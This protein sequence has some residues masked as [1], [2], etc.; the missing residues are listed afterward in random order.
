MQLGPSLDQCIRPAPGSQFPKNA[1]ELFALQNMRIQPDLGLSLDSSV[2]TIGSCFARNI[3]EAMSSVG[4]DVPMLGFRVPRSEWDGAR[5]N[6]I[7]NRYTPYSISQLVAWVVAAIED[8]D[9]FDELTNRFWVQSEPDL[10]V[11]MDLGGLVAVSH[12]RF[13]ARRRELLDVFRPMTSAELI[14]ITLGQTESWTYEPNGMHWSGAPAVASLRSLWPL[15]R[16]V[17]ADEQAAYDEIAESIALVRRIN[18]HAHILLTISPVPASRYWSGSPALTEYWHSKLTLWQAA[19]RLVADLEGV[20]YFASFEAV[21]LAPDSWSP[22]RLHVTDA[23]VRLVVEGML[24]A[25]LDADVVVPQEGDI[26]YVS[27][28]QGPETSLKARIARRMQRRSG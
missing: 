10:G 12:E 20:H 19:Q 23:T 21:H 7:L 9:A 15:T 16:L 2:I 13:L 26:G 24:R 18:P 4:F 1:N 6:G 8:A 5:P 27:N 22:D 3:E 28:V 17:T 11:D 25:N 14:V